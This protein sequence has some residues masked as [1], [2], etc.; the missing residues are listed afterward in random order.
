MR[1]ALLAVV[2]GLSLVAL[3][4]AAGAEQL[5][6][7]G[8]FTVHSGWKSIGDTI[9]AAEGRTYGF[10]S[11]WGVVFNDKGSGPL[12]SGPVVCPY[13]LEIVGGVLSA[14]GQCSWSDL[15]GDK[16]FTDWTGSLPPNSQ[17]DG[18]NEITGGTGKYAGIQGKAPFHC[19]PLNANGQWACTQQFEYRL[20]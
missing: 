19:R 2:S 9:Q 20:P 16:I 17:F 5:P 6:K 1:K 15:D 10:G 3:S 13:T 11:F 18:L 14:K 7:F 4:A 12:H 8:S